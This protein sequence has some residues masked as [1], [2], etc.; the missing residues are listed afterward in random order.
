MGTSAIRPTL[1]AVWG[2]L[3]GTGASLRG[4]AAA[5]RGASSRGAPQYLQKRVPETQCPWQRTQVTILA[6]T[7]PE[8]AM[9]TTGAPTIWS[10]VNATKG[11]GLGA[12]TGGGGGPGTGSTAGPPRATAW[13]SEVPHV[14]QKRYSGGFGVWHSTQR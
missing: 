1:P 4:A 12:G 9:S 7:E 5:G 2:D 8:A 3:I 11:E 6:G 13:L 10:P 14:T